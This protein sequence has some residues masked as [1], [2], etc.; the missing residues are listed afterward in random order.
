MG[1]R[2]LYNIRV[3]D[4]STGDLHGIWYDGLSL[5]YTK[6]LN[7][8]GMCVWT[9]HPDHPVLALIGEDDRVEVS[10]TN[11]N[12][13]VDFYA[14]TRDFVGVYREQ[15]VATDQ[16][17]NKYVA[18]YIPSAEETLSRSIVA[19]KAGTANRSEHTGQT[20]YGIF[21][22]VWQY[23]ATSNGTTADGRERNAVGLNS[24]TPAGSNFSSTTI[25][26]RCAWK[27]TLT[28]MQELAELGGGQF[29][30]SRNTSTNALFLSAEA[31]TDVSSDVIFS[32]PLNTLGS[33]SLQEN[34]MQEKTAAIV[35]GAGQ[36]SS[37]TV[38]VRTG[39][40]QSS[41][42]DYEIF[43]DYK[44]TSTT[45]ILDDRGDIVMTDRQARQT[46]D[47]DVLQ[48]SGYAY[49]NDYDLGN[50]VSVDFS[51]T[52]VTKQIDTVSVRFNPYMS[53]SISLKDTL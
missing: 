19:Y 1:Y 49:P 47:G 45:S 16:S 14:W 43:V 28:A 34:K 29:Y 11:G 53:V 6:K 20:I 42:N 37:R 24:T 13:V 36:E 18:L 39:P 2:R 10:I 38:Q 25:D 4:Q 35:G 27:N 40:N 3:Y 50:I 46:I 15:Q 21:I 12:S 44:D 32:L 51:G 48:S 30:V 17:G 33:T 52:V 5:E 31:P 23:N 26:Y 8:I 41:T 7:D 22:N 9:V